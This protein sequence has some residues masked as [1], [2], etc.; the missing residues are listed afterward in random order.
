M[1]SSQKN[2]LST[3]KINLQTF[4]YFCSQKLHVIFVMF[5]FNIDKTVYSVDGLKKIAK[6]QFLMLLVCMHVY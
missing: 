4:R 6:R 3:C 5:D 1:Q 2:Q